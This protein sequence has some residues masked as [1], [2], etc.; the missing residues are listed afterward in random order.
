MLGKYL[1]ENS[2]ICKVIHAAYAMA[3]TIAERLGM[4]I[5]GKGKKQE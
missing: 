1:E 2:D 5:T 4:N 3:R